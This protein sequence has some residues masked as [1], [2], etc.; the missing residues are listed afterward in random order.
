MYRII[1]FVILLVFSIGMSYALT[2]V[3]TEAQ[4]AQ[5][6]KEKASLFKNALLLN[7]LISIVLPKRPKKTLSTIPV[8]TC[9]T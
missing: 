1:A 3:I 8:T 7:L 5:N 9:P 4:V 6:N 2:P